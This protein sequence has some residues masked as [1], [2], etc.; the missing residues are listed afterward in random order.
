VRIG[1][2]RTGGGWWRVPLVLLLWTPVAAAIVG[3]AIGWAILRDL[4]S[5]LPAAPDLARWE[6]T[7]PRTT[8]LVAAD[9][10]VLAEIPFDDDGHAVHRFPLPFDAL[11][12]RLVQAIVAAEDIRFF[13]HDGVDPRAVVRAAWANYRAG[14]VVEGAST[15]TQQ[16]AR[17]LLPGSIGKVETMRR[18]VREA[19]VARRLERRY[20]KPRILAAYATYVFLGAGAYGVQAA[21]RA[22]FD[23]PLDELD[24][25]ETAMIAGLA[26]AP[27]RADPYKDAAAARARR[28]Q[29]LDRMLAAGFVDAAAHAAA[30]A[31][32]IA[33][34]PPV[35]R[36]GTLAPWTTEAAR[37]EAAL[38]AA[39]WARGGLVVE[40]TAWPTLD[41]AAREVATAH[42]AALG[43]GRPAG[44]PE[45]ALLAIDR[46][47]GYA[48][49]HVGGV[50]AGD[51]RAGQFDRALQACRQPGSAFKPLVY[52]AALE[53]GAITPGTPLRDAPVSEYDDVSGHWKPKSGHGF[54]GV[55]V[56]D[57]ALAS[58]LNAPA[59][60]VFDR[61]GAA[62]VIGLAR[63]LGITTE[64]AAL[65]PLVLGASC[66][67]PVELLAA[68]GA[69]AAG[70]V[71]R[72]PIFVRAI[73][74]GDDV[75]VDRASPFDPE[76]DPG[77]RLDRM[78]AEVTA[79][80]AARPALD[81]VAAFLMSSMLRDVV[82]R[83]TGAPARALGRPA[84][85]KTGTTNENTD[86]W[87]VGYTGRTLAAVWLGHDDARRRLGPKDD[88]GHAALPLWIALIRR[89]EGAPPAEVPGPAP[90]DV[91][92]VRV[93]RDTGNLAAPGSGGALDLYFRRGSEPVQRADAAGVPADLSRLSG[94]F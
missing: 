66:V 55:V 6:A 11:P 28:D 5:D 14:R 38:D 84:A 9:G 10:T 67:K 12:P 1:N 63:R 41:A 87:F 94:E 80:A 22:Y 7:L 81:P 42:A 59:I 17:G 62:R 32:P 79:R 64:L 19:L 58:S 53:S 23:R 26:Q 47:T 31:R 36:L 92:L 57:D 86:A 44:A 16:L 65:R 21:A 77:R 82:L 39:R 33:L 90:A 48:L 70:G 75:L 54:R 74:R 91:A 3:G 61:V 85:G 18:K 46:L 40:T 83:G 37:R 45:V 4:A 89:I 60:D 35:Q 30:R 8:R 25:A 76:I 43:R 93:D 20:D 51:R 49:A 56:A 69:F 78:V 27:G 68:Y 73:R 24:L 2:R 29:V 15:L 88:G 71:P 34:T 52:A 50:G 72:P 13:E